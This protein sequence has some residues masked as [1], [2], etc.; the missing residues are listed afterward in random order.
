MT[1]GEEKS[2]GRSE[3]NAWVAKSSCAK[4]ITEPM[5]KVNPI[6]EF[7]VTSVYA[8]LN[9]QHMVYI[10]NP[11]DLDSVVGVLRDYRPSMFVSALGL[12][13]VSALA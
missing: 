1:D 5:G 2:G 11:R 8:M 12:A 3:A 13:T 4:L 7:E 6:R 9:G 10:P